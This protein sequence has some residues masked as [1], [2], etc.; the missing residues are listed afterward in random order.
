MTFSTICCCS[1][2]SCKLIWYFL[3]TLSNAFS[4]ALVNQYDHQIIDVCFNCLSLYV[5]KSRT[6]QKYTTW[7]TVQFHLWVTSSAVAILSAIFDPETTHEHNNKPFFLILLFIAEFLDGSIR[8]ELLW[9]GKYVMSIQNTF[10]A[11]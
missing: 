5:W 2:F 3:F 9:L 6:E 10:P 7:C 8:N 4:M 11:S 1:L